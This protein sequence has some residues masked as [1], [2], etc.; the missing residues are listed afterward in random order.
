M[1]DSRLL[2]L[3]AIRTRCAVDK[4]F[5]QLVRAL[6]AKARTANAR[7]VVKLY[8]RN[9]IGKQIRQHATMRRRELTHGTPCY[10]C[11]S[12]APTTKCAC[13]EHRVCHGCEGYPCD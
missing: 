8:V 5:I 1:S 10:A 13:G 6:R 2:V 12:F 7:A 4:K 9:E 11:L 3:D